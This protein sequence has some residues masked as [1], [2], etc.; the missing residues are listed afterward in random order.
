M[1]IS[2][3]TLL[4]TE[5]RRGSPIF[6]PPTVIG[7]D[8]LAWRR[9]RKPAVKLSITHKPLTLFMLCRPNFLESFESLMIHC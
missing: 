1:S 5:R 7:I 9:N 2:N 6:A 3:D 4:R 8:D